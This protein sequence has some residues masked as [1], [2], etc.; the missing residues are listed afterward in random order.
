MRIPDDA[1]LADLAAFEFELG[2]DEADEVTA[3]CQDGKGAGQDEVEGDEG[4]IDNDDGGG[5][6]GVGKGEVAAIEFFPGDDAGILAQFPGELVR[7]DIEGVDAEGA[8]LEEAIGEAAGRSADIDGDFVLGIDGEG[9]QGGFEFEAAAA[10]E[11]GLF[12][13][14][15]DGVLGDFL[16]GFG[17]GDALHGDL[18]GEDEAFGLFPGV[19]EGAFHQDLVEALAQGVMISERFKASII[20]RIFP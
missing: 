11:P 4:D 1:A 2:F 17:M 5:F 10:D 9:V 3:G 14:V 18:T 15:D 13:E 12:L 19:G 8:A 6:S 20:L 16:A 7:A